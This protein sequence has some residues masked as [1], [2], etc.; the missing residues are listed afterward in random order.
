MTYSEKMLR[1]LEQQDLDLAQEYFLEAI[2][3]DDDG[4]LYDLGLYLESL[5][6]KLNI[7]TSLQL[8]ETNMSL[9][10]ALL[11]LP[12][13]DSHCAPSLIFFRH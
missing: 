13:N 3:K 5:G 1:A 9:K 2:R 12:A 8:Y 4:T 10:S 11:L 6:R 7:H